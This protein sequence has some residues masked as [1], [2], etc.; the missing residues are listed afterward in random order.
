ML[1]ADCALALELAQAMYGLA[2]GQA[3]EVPGGTVGYTFSIDGAFFLKLYDTRLAITGRCTQRLTEQLRVLDWMRHTPMGERICYP[4]KTAEGAFTFRWENIIGVM[5]N[6]IPG[7][8]L[9]FSKEYTPEEC[10]WLAQT[11]KILHGL[12][13]GPVRELCP[14]ERFENGFFETLPG[15]MERTAGRHPE[16]FGRLMKENQS[17]VQARMDWVLSLAGQIQGMGLQFVLCHTD[18]HGGNIMKTPQGRLYLVDWENMMLAPR[19]ADL[20]W[21]SERADADLFCRGANAQALAYY[22]MRRDLED[23]FEF[24]QSLVNG[25]YSVEEQRTVYGHMERILGHLRNVQV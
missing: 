11:I 22:R 25:E 12:E 16:S 23:I 1:N 9:G 5:F 8:A 3:R 17:M 24:C 4:I 6:L 18:I 20:Y 21:F 7:Q 13:V 10:Q 19:E 14:Q 15:L 2:A